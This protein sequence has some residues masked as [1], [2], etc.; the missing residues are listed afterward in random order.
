MF[1]FISWLQCSAPAA[2]KGLR[3][4][5]AELPETGG[6]ARERLRLWGHRVPGCGKALE[7]RCCSY[8]PGNA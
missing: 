2:G 5:R 6:L 1:G 4:P 8:S 3:S 7:G